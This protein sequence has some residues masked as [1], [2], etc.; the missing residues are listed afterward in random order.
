MSAVMTALRSRLHGQAVS[1]GSLLAWFFAWLPFTYA[2]QVFFDAP[3]AAFVAWVALLL[4]IA[5]LLQDRA[6][7][8]RLLD[9]RQRTIPD[10]VMLYAALVGC[11]WAVVEWLGFGPGLGGRV[12][13][14]QVAPLAL[15]FIASTLQRSTLELICKIVAITALLV[16]A[17][18]FYENLSGKLTLQPTEFQWASFGYVLGRSGRE[19]TQLL[20]YTYR[21]PGLLEHVHATTCFA[22]LGALVAWTF[23]YRTASLR[24]LSVSLLLLAAIYMH[25]SRL[26]ALAAIVGMAALHAAC[27][28]LDPPARRRIVASA[29]CVAL[30]LGG[31]VI[32]DPLG[33][34][35]HYYSPAIKEG[36]FQIHGGR[37]YR[38]VIG[39]EVDRVHDSLTETSHLALVFGMGPGSL[40]RDANASSDDFFIVQLAAQYGY[41]G[42][43][44]LVGAIGY[45]V[46]KGVMRLARVDVLDRQLVLAAVSILFVIGATALHSSTLQRK[47]IYP[48]FCFALGVLENGRRRLPAGAGAER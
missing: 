7:R 31:L 1:D 45:L 12:L 11:F 38:S 4:L 26:S 3:A 5:R 42:F 18:M 46:S 19:L 24:W 29:V 25:G 8:T 21:P 30:V 34:T 22:A 41:V 20:Y 17:E 28:R 15:Y 6:A 14:L 10:T 44:L 40:M 32:F 27:A 35:R 39:E 36:N 48:V 43:T 13:L 9:W 33:T 47:A 2:L 16:G 23:F 37:S